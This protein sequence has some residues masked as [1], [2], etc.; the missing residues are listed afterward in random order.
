VAE[1]W[2]VGRR[3]QGIESGDRAF[4][5]R[6]H[7]DRGIVASGHFSGVVFQGPHW[8]GSRRE[9]NYAPILWDAVLEVP[10]RLPIEELKHRVAPFPWD[11]LQGSGV[12][13]TDSLVLNMEDLWWRH[14]IS[15]GLAPESNPD[16]VLGTG[17]PEGSVERV[18]VNRYERDPR[19]RAACL[20]HYGTACTVC[21]FDF[22][23]TYGK[24]ARG[25]K[26]IHVHHLLELSSVGKGYR[27]DPIKDLRPVC[28]NCHMMLHLRHP[29]FDISEL[30]AMLRGT[31]Q[32]SS[33]HR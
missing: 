19:A 15:V 30:R 6:H 33:R 29:V 21:G 26:G 22:E 20:A 12:R 27:V 3:R 25:G 2:S 13:L 17:Y 32:R 31:T 9:A 28:P 16:E 11:R 14:L 8:D 5:L 7:V 4:L 24:F 18:T 10:D 23:K 1:Q